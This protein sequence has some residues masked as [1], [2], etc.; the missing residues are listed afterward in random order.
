LVFSKNR[1]YSF[2]PMAEEEHD[3]PY[4]AEYA[5]SNRSSCKSCKSVI[6]KDS[7]RIARMVQSPHFDG[8]I[9]HWYHYSCFFKKFLP[10]ST[11][12]VSGYHGLRWEDQE[13]IKEHLSG[14]GSGSGSGKKG[15][16]SAEQKTTQLNHDFQVE[17]AKSGRSTCRKCYQL[18]EKGALRVAK[19][20]EPDPEEYGF[21]GE[22]IP[23]WHHYSCLKKELMVGGLTADMIP[24]FKQLKKADKDT[25]NEDLGTAVA[26]GKKRGAGGIEETDAPAGKKSKEEKKEE[27]QLKDQSQLLWSVR[28][29][30]S[31]NLSMAEMRELL[32]HN[33]QEIPSG[34]SKLLDRCCDGMVFGALKKCTTCKA[35]QL[36]YSS[37]ACCYVCT[38]NISGWT[39]CSAQTQEPETVAWKIPAGMKENSDELKKFKFSKRARVF[40]KLTAPPKPTKTKSSESTD[41]PSKEEPQTKSIPQKLASV[42]TKTLLLGGLNVVI[43]GR[44]SKS[45][46][47]L[48][49]S[50]TKLG[51]K[52]VSKATEEVDICISKKDEVV[53]LSS[54]MLDVKVADIPVVDESVLLWTPNPGDSPP[55][56]EDN[57]ISDW[58]KERFKDSYSAPSKRLPSKSASVP[59]AKKQKVVVKGGAVVDA[60]SGLAHSHHIFQNSGNTYN[61]VLGMVDIKRGTNSYYKLQILEGD[62]NKSFYLFRS[63]G[64][65]GTDI[66]GNK[67]DHM[68]TASEAVREFERVY[69][70]KTG[71]FFQ[72]RKNFVKH[73]N[74]FYPLEMDYGQDDDDLTSAMASAGS[75]SKL[76]PKVQDLIRMIFDVEKMKQSMMEFEI[77]MQKMPLGKLSKKQIQ[78][79]YEVLSAA[80]RELEGDKDP[81][82]LLDCSNQFFTLIPHDFGMKKPPL[83]DSEKFIKV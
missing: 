47:K 9:P 26:S 45:Q 27:K 38:G 31:R 4:K 17:Y 79:A 60:D 61:A 21:S 41:G 42:D 48:A 36:V 71:N 20:E 73:P 63:W 18:I 33:R 24:G 69:E 30:L 49:E 74:K 32:T 56:L 10:G 59:A 70:E 52:V 13:K 51:G 1:K 12:D 58:G 83:L 54:K 35:G 46:A 57:C 22:R 50:V 39:K 3:I 15:S 62:S 65:V 5:K 8:K 72:Q 34:E 11:A 6:S 81:T 7:L 16:G 78:S 80:Q 29:M 2:D 40:P 53:K 44:L 55:S 25:M 68:Y 28:D 14:K 43:V 64:R 75:K 76:D 37:T 77:D 82:K 66:G 67:C 19:M 23:R